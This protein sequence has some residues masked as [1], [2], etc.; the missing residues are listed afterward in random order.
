MSIAVLL[1]LTTWACWI[2]PS[3][4]TIVHEQ[5]VLPSFGT[6]HLR[7]AVMSDIHAGAPFIDLAKLQ[8]IVDRTNAEH[9]DLTCLLG[10]YVIQGVRGGHFME[11]ETIARELGRLRA[12]LGVFAVLGNHDGWFDGPR[13]ATALSGAGIRVLQDESTLVPSSGGA[14]WLVGITDFGTGPHDVAAALSGVDDPDRPVIAMTHNPDL[15]PRIPDRV[16]LT[17]SGH[18]HGGQVW[19]PFIG[20]PIVPSVFG[21]RYAAGH[22]VEGGRQLFV[23]TGIGTSIIPVRFG[24]PPSIAILTLAGP[25]AH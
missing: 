25:S 16:A 8:T 7:V 6:R 13:V 4:L 24:V 21:Q 12:S 3:R 14:V 5:I 18:T 23:T 9:P 11:P 15:F 22:I 20:A 17:L 10:D 19:L 1:A 2:E